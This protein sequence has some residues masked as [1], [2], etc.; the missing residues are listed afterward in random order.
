MTLVVLADARRTRP[1][2]RWDGCAGP[3]CPRAPDST[4][5]SAGGPVPVCA[6]CRTRALCDPAYAARL[7]LA[8]S[9]G[10]GGVL[11]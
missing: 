8:D 1:A 7:G 5:R 4:L 6:V 9:D 10:G 2:P 11:A 3:G